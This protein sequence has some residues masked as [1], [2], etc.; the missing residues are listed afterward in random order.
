[1]FLGPLPPQPTDPN[2]SSR[3]EAGNKPSSC[4]SSPKH[5]LRLKKKK[6]SRGPEGRNTTAQ[7]SC[8]TTFNESKMAGAARERRG[9]D[10]A[11]LSAYFIRIEGPGVVALISGGP[12]EISL[13]RGLRALTGYWPRS[14][15]LVGAVCHIF[16]EGTTN[17]WALE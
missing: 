4:L 1:M 16:P 11:T 13:Q 6:A 9:L 17:H 7:N 15:V 10:L 12:E 2:R 8:S 14:A 3:A 5:L